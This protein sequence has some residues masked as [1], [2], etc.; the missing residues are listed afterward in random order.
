MPRSGLSLHSPDSRKLPALYEPELKHLS[1]KRAILIAGPTASGKSQ[2]A[3][4]IASA[5]G[6]M[7]V[8]AD[9]L[10]VYSCWRILTARPTPQDE[11]KVPHSLYGHVQRTEKYSVGA[12]LK[13]IERLLSE[14]TATPIVIVGGTGLYFTALTD[15]FSFIPAV[16][17]SVTTECDD[18]VSERGLEGLLRD[19]AENDAESL[20]RID[21]SNAARVRRAWEVWRSTGRG[22]AYWQSL[23]GT[24]VLKV[25]ECERLVLNPERDSLARRIGI[26]LETMLDHGLIEECKAAVGE[27]DPSLPSSRAIGAKQFISHLAG[28]LSLDEAIEL[29]EIA[30]RQYAKRQRTWFRNRMK[31]WNW[32]SQH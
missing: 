8:N 30:T 10:Q 23:P 32:I 19:L 16:P 4:K 20:S 15:G 9:A 12:W 29:T 22:I 25:D 1:A 24:P 27:W 28:E 14:T 18:A 3:M 11:A 2:L 21:R 31:G 13:E 5:L 17:R 6:G 26:R 7:I